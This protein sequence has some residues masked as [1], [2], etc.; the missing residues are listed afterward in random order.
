VQYVKKVIGSNF[1]QQ[2]IFK[3]LW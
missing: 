1:M 2:Q 3:W